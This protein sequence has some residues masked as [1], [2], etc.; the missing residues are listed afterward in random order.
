MFLLRIQILP[1]SWQKFILKNPVKQCLF[2][3]RILAASESISASWSTVRRHNKLS[4]IFFL[5]CYIRNYGISAPFLSAIDLTLSP[6]SIRLIIS[7]FC[8]KETCFLLDIV[9]QFNSPY[10]HAS[11]VKRLHCTLFD[12]FVKFFQLGYKLLVSTWF[13]L[14]LI[15]QIH[16]Q[17]RLYLRRHLGTKLLEEA[18]KWD[19]P[20]CLV[21]Y[22]LFDLWKKNYMIILFIII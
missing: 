13:F 5:F 17:V 4:D 8:C 11:G 14:S 6:D 18:P 7:N 16:F 22:L 10:Q 20:T 2:H 15:T 19:L 3:F 1:I 12:H 21:K 9:Q